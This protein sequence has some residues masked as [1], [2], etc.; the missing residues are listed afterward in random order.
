[1]FT[2]EV[3]WWFF[4]FFSIPFL[5]SHWHKQYSY[6]LLNQL[7]NDFYVTGQKLGSFSTALW[8]SAHVFLGILS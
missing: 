7:K 2:D 3:C 1:M 6:A 8:T 4:F 5:L